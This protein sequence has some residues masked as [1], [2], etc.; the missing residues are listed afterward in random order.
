MSK[1]STKTRIT[2]LKEY[3]TTR[4]S[5]HKSKVKLTTYNK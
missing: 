2:Q 4:Q 5:G 1:N 3:L